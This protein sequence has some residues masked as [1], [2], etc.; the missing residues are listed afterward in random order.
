MGR[1]CVHVPASAVFVSGVRGWG[2]WSGSV[3]QYCLGARQPRACRRWVGRASV[4]QAGPS[5]AHQ[6]CPALGG[7]CGTGLSRQSTPRGPGSRPWPAPPEWVRGVGGRA[8]RWAYLTRGAR[9]QERGRRGS[10]APHFSSAAAASI[11]PGVYS[12]TCWSRAAHLDKPPA[13]VED[14]VS[15]PL[16]RRDRL[17]RAAREQGD[18]GAR[19]RKQLLERAPRAG[20]AAVEED[21]LADEG[22]AEV[23]LEGARPGAQAC[24]FELRGRTQ[25]KALDLPIQVASF[26]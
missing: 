14:D 19:P 13:A 11:C 16:G 24:V 20:A 23:G 1:A 4:A 8:Q 22:G 17:G 10:A 6:S 21:P 9:L 2:W 26:I 5:S 7:G 25:D 15:A 18:R 3:A 12:A